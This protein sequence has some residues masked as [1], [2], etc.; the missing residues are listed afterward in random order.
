MLQQVLEKRG[1][2]PASV[3]QLIERLQIEMRM[4][5]SVG[6][7]EVDVHM[8]NIDDATWRIGRCEND[9]KDAVLPVVRRVYNAV[10]EQRL[11]R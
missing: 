3:E 1:S 9:A 10:F 4:V 5:L 6:G 2:E 7:Y 11:Y 8:S